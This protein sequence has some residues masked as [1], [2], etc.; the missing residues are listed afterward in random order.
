VEADLGQQIRVLVKA[1]N[2]HGFSVT[3]MNT[4]A[5]PTMLM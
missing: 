5:D 3:Y 1:T 4:G 2:A